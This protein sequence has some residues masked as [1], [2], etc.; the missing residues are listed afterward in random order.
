MIWSVVV[1]KG[2]RYIAS[3]DS[4]GSVIFWDIE[5][6]IMVQ[7]I[8][9]HLAD[10]LCMG[11]DESSEALYV[12]GVDHKLS[13]FK[14]VKGIDQWVEKFSKRTHTHDVR[15][16][17]IEN[18]NGG[19]VVTGGVD[20]RM[21]VN[22][23]EDNGKFN[24][25]RMPVFPPQNEFISVSKRPDS[26]GRV[27]MTMKNH[28]ELKIWKVKVTND[29]GEQQ[30]Q[31]LLANH[32]QQNSACT[33]KVIVKID[34]KSNLVATGVSPSGKYIVVSDTEKVRLFEVLE[35]N[36][37]DE[38][39]IVKRVDNLLVGRREDKEYVTKIHF[40]G[41]DDNENSGEEMI[42]LATSEL[43]IYVIQNLASISVNNTEGINDK[44]DNT[45][46]EAASSGNNELVYKK[47][48][49]H[50]DEIRKEFTVIGQ[51]RVGGAG[52]IIGKLRNITGLSTFGESRYLVSIDSGNRIAI[53]DL[54]TNALVFYSSHTNVVDEGRGGDDGENNTGVIY[55]IN[56]NTI[57][58]NNLVSLILGY[59]N[60]TISVLALAMASANKSKKSHED[61]AKLKLKQNFGSILEIK[62]KYPINK[63]LT[64]NGSVYVYGVNYIYK[65]DITSLLADATTAGKS[66]VNNG[67]ENVTV[68]NIDENNKHVNKI[69]NQSIEHYNLFLTNNSNKVNLL[70]R[71]ISTLLKKTNDKDNDLE[72]LTSQ[73]LKKIRIL[74]C[75]IDQSIAIPA[76]T[77]SNDVS[78]SSQASNLTYKAEIG[79]GNVIFVTKKYNSIMFVDFI[80]NSSASSSSNDKPVLFMVQRYWFDTLSALPKSFEGHK[81]FNR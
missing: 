75:D 59:N 22:C 35:N 74:G 3:G 63:I 24:S 41:T 60:N 31:Q 28:E 18:G 62:E 34:G 33:E 27:I 43:N 66:A 21:M 54:K 77:S 26:K 56:V 5:M 58:N 52:S 32:R 30:A 1:I 81:K 57:V 8:Q 51:Q 17:G 53:T 72:Y 6:E 47:I 13:Q 37:N 20:G 48:E 15:A 44:T 68:K 45:T 10:I 61:A 69:I 49:S 50:H 9:S 14:K 2:T 7:K 11:Y 67:L 12:S 70:K 64:S 4:T 39:A 40:A 78:E 38:L 65:V 23:E 46:G 42:V 55:P 71:K 79:K 80:Q 25:T 19:R 76:K 73:T 29:V 36:E 16:I